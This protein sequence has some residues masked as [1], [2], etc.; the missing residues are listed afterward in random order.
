MYDILVI[1]LSIE[2]IYARQS[3]HATQSQH[4]LQQYL[5]MGAQDARPEQSELVTLSLSRRT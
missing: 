2:G 1:N 3:V 5:Q 4:L